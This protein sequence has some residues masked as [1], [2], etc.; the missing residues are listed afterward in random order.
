MWFLAWFSRF[1]APIATL[2][3][4]LFLQTPFLYMKRRGGLF[5]LPSIGFCI[6]SL[7][8]SK[9]AGLHY[10]MAHEMLDFQKAKVNKHFVA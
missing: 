6:D 8:G 3:P 10:A 1:S 4:R 7:L 2:P 9:Y 5:D